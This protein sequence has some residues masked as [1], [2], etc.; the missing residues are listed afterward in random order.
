M[1][2]FL[3]VGNRAAT[4]PFN[5]NDLPGAGRMDIMCRCVAQALFV[6]HGIRRDVEIYLVLLGE[7]DPLKTVLVRGSGVRY[8]APDE[9]NIAGII[10]KALGA[11]AGKEWN[12]SSPGVYVARKGLTEILDATPCKVVYLREDG[13]DI[14]KIA[15][16][17]KNCMFVLGDH[18]GLAE[19]EEKEVMKRAWKVVRVSPISLQ[20]DQCIVIVHNELDRVSRP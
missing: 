14:R 15:S 7:P 9:R 19:E 16:N 11:K 6:S 3:V 20:A 17:L 2:A 5:L 10:R 1:R 8:M 4:A 18:L 13:E 12:K